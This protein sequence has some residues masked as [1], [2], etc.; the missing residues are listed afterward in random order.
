M[1]KED[2]K[3]KVHFMNTI[4][5]IY[6]SFLIVNIFC[7]HTEYINLV[8]VSQSDKQK[9]MLCNFFYKITIFLFLISK[10]ILFLKYF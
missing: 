2:V 7:F 10:N 4:I 3:V 6:I 5:L 1:E 9:L 8:T